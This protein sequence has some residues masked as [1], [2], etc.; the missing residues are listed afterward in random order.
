M[1]SFNQD[2]VTPRSKENIN[3]NANHDD[4]NDSVMQNA[5]VK[6]DG[7]Y[8][9]SGHDDKY[10]MAESCGLSQPAQPDAPGKDW[11]S[12][13]IIIDSGKSLSNTQSASSTSISQQES[14]TDKEKEFRTWL[15]QMRME[16]RNK[17]GHDFEILNSDPL[18]EAD[19]TYAFEPWIDI[20]KK[21]RKKLLLWI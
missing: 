6:Q 11:A 5:A 1:N 15:F 16:L 14:M 13:F 19:G 18:I 10:S 4:H 17:I 8:Q 20:K 7:T 12:K 9:P 21:K 2:L 3:M